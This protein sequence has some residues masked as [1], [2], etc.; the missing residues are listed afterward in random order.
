MFRR[1][2]LGI[3]ACSLLLI[4]ST[5]AHGETQPQWS[6]AQLTAGWLARALADQG[7]LALRDTGEVDYASTAYAILGMKASGVAALQIVKSGEAM[8]SSDEA[9][10]GTSD[11]IG[12][13]T[14]AIALMILAMRAA[15]L[16]P[17]DYPTAHGTR[18][19]YEDLLSAVR[20]DGSIS[21]WASAYGQSFAI[22]ALSTATVTLDR[23]IT[24]WLLAQPCTDA[25]SA[26]YG[27][28]G[29]SGPG[30]CE[31]ADPDSTALAVLAL[32]HVGVSLDTLAPSRA[33]LWSVMDDHGG[34]VSP[35]SSANTNTTGLAL[36]ALKASDPAGVDADKMS[37]AENY[38]MSVRLD[39]SRTINISLL[40]AMVYD[41]TETLPAP[42]D[43]FTLFGSTAQGVW[44]LADGLFL[45]AETGV[46]DVPGPTACEV[47][48][49]PPVTQEEEP[50]NLWWIAILAVAVLGIAVITWRVVVKRSTR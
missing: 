15:D 30:S 37:S 45:N 44:G 13:K 25:A 27:G 22:L 38:L 34:F 12:S 29:F 8:A 28:Y 40:D 16:D 7:N 31:D 35:F 47:D 43:S 19:L 50:S 36:A 23:K 33:Y 18:N 46:L 1:L 32:A 39:C 5:P 6:S 41:L 4:P 24:D 49:S 42:E 20:E 21:D 14:T 11:E 3:L 26:G 17:S 9:F 2:A 10:I 48:A